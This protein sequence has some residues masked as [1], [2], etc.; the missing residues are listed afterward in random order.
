[1]SSLQSNYFDLDSHQFSISNIQ[2]PLL[3]QLLE[4]QQLKSSLALPAGSKIIDFGCGSGRLSIFF[5]SHGYHVTAIDIS[6]KSL[7]NLRN[8]YKHL[9]RP[10][11]GKLTLS[12]K[13][14]QTLFDG[15]VGSDI[16]HHVQITQILPKLFLLLK[17]TGKAVFSEPNALNIFWY[18][19]Y[20]TYHI[21]WNIESGILQNNFF[22]L[23]SLFKS[24][25]FSQIHLQGHGLLPSRILNFSPKLCKFNCF[26]LGNIFFLRPFAY[27]FI[28][29]AKK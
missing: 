27:R 1:M 11:W 26:F 8:T 25:N 2:Q 10:G 13:L 15:I 19:Y 22:N 18:I 28:I 12:Q 9:Y 20:F 14:P 24:S 6:P 23:S 29:S 4:M 21:P 7:A 17:P 5:L 3:S 16:L